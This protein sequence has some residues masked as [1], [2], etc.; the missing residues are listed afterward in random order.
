V[1]QIGAVNGQSQGSTDLFRVSSSAPPFLMALDLRA[2]KPTAFLNIL[3]IY[4]VRNIWSEV[5]RRN[6]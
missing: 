6:R 4:A 2:M 5:A 1:R 3:G